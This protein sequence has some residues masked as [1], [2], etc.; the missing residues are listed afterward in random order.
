MKF[1]CA[2]ATA[3]GCPYTIEFK[4]NGS[5]S[6]TVTQT[7]A[8]QFHDPSSPEDHAHLRMHPQLQS[9]CA[10]LL[11][12][13]VKPQQACNELNMEAHRM[14]LLGSKGSALQQAS[15]ARAS[16]TLA[17]VRA[18]AKQVR[19]ANGYGLT[20]DASAIT[21]QLEEYARRDCVPFFQPYR[22]KSEAGKGQP[23]IIILQTPFQQRMLGQFGRHLVF[24]DATFGTN[25]YGYPLYAV[26]VS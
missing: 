25:K 10:L 5:G 23:L 2:R 3:C 26:S 17:Q 11:R 22:A 1:G 9:I 6:V 16:I 20:S 14:G 18:V 8:H 7:E 12:L 21:A 4:H 19:R 24:M 15:N 13:G